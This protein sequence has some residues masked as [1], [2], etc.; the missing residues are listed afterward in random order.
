MEDLEGEVGLCIKEKEKDQK[1]V[2][3]HFFYGRVY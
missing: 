2:C 1:A 3:H